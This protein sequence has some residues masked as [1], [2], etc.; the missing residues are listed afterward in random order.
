MQLQLVLDDRTGML[1]D[2]HRRL[3][4]HYGP[5]EP[6]YPLDPVS[7]L[8]SGLIGTRTYGAV[9]GA[10]FL[11]LLARYGDWAA[12]RDAPAE[13]I[14]AVID[15]VS[16]ADVKARHLR[17]TLAAITGANG[18]PTLDWLEPL[19]TVEALARLKRLDGV[20]IK[21]AAATLN[22]STLRRAVLVIDT[23]HLRVLRRLGLVGRHASFQ[24]AYDAIAPILPPDWRAEDFDTHHRLMKLLGQ[25][26]CRAR[27]ADCVA[28]PL[29]PVCPSTSIVSSSLGVTDQAGPAST[30]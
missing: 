4:D 29:T 6:V 28:C 19:S 7:Q 24:E 2:I 3:A 1:A 23:H 21:V 10:A 11:D 27:G 5:L 22:F 26:V 17:S 15:S 18:R 9:S 30:S 8:V 13:D 20:G 25:T 14:E 12:V 16:F